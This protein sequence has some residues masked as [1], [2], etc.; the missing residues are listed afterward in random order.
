MYREAAYS[1]IESIEACVR[2][3]QEELQEDISSFREA[4]QLLALL[5]VLRNSV[6]SPF[7]KL[8][9]A[10]AVFLAEASVAALN[11]AAPVY[12]HLNRFILK[13]AS[14]QL[15]GVPM[16][17]MLHSG[18]SGISSHS[19][20]L[21]RELTIAATTGISHSVKV[22]AHALAAPDSLS[23]SAA[24]IRGV[25]AATQSPITCCKLLHKGTLI[26]VAAIV[27]Q[28][29]CTI[30]ATSPAAGQHSRAEQDVVVAALSALITF[31]RVKK[32][33]RAETVQAATAEYSAVLWSLLHSTSSFAHRLAPARNLFTE[34]PQAV[35][36]IPCWHT[37]LLDVMLMKLLQLAHAVLLQSRVWHTE[38]A[39][40]CNLNSTFWT[41][42]VDLSS[43]HTHTPCYS[44]TCM[45]CCQTNDL[46]QCLLCLPADFWPTQGL[47]AGSRV[48]ELPPLPH[49]DP[50]QPDHSLWPIILQDTGRQARYRSFPKHLR[51]VE[52][53]GC[54][55]GIP[56]VQNGTQRVG[57][58]IWYRNGVWGSDGSAEHPLVRCLAWNVSAMLQKVAS[59]TEL[60]RIAVPWRLVA[61]DL[62]SLDA[63]DVACIIMCC[64]DTQL[65]MVACCRAPVGQGCAVLCWGVCKPGGCTTLP[66]IC[67]VCIRF[68][69]CPRNGSSYTSLEKLHQ[70]HRYWFIGPCCSVQRGRRYHWGS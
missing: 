33:W 36:A 42:L 6:E 54:P 9:R 38:A 37:E 16:L 51:A 18:L 25:L 60:R 62:L 27:S 31:S 64:S 2:K 10:S 26:H 3:Q 49:N 47:V 53:D 44:P 35:H 63:A 41:A 52:R 28:Y 57:Q 58:E 69:A 17:G 61:G 45:I 23:L 13:R 24:V 43:I 46:Q 66:C 39:A 34:P 55:A 40:A 59:D 30:A 11:P 5:A 21:A 14:L 70:Q 50:S 15:H 29:L 4:P 56:A 67:Q 48:S 7:Q 8:P 65:I 12:S 68:Q 32:L 1:A 19:Q 20:S 22:A